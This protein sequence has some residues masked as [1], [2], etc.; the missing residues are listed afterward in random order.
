LSG[1]AIAL[2]LQAPRSESFPPTEQG[3][4]GKTVRK[5]TI[6]NLTPATV[7]LDNGVIGADFTRSNDGCANQQMAFRDKCTVGVTFSPLGTTPTGPVPAETL[8]YGFAYGSPVINGAVSVPLK[9]RVK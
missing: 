2:R 1:D 5:V 7:T 8:S 4:T 3:T 6:T 9:G